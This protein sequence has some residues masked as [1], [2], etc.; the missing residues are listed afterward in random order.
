MTV[1]QDIQTRFGPGAESMI[2]P[3]VG[4][5]PIG[6]GFI[7]PAAVDRARGALVG[8]AIGEALGEPVEDRSRQWIAARFG[9]INGFV[10]PNPKTGSDTLLTLITA[11]SLLAD[12]SDHPTRFAARILGASIDTRGVSV[13]H[14]QAA[15]QAGQQWWQAALADSAGTAGAARCA[16]FGLLW[17]GDPQRA[18]YEAA[19]ST[20]VTHGHPAATAGAAAFAAAVA[21]AATGDGPLDRSWLESVADIC[22]GFNQGSVNGATVAERLRSL[23]SMLGQ[24]PESALNTIGTSPVVWQAVPAALWCAAAH[25]NPVA[26]VLAAVNAGGDTDTIAAMTGA[27]LG[28]RFGDGAWPQQLRNVDGVQAVVDVADRLAG[29]V[30]GPSPQNTATNSGDTPVHVSFLLDRSGSM[31]GLVDDVIGGFNAFVANQRT[32]TGDCAFTA[33]QFDSHNPFEIIHAAIPIV[34]VPNLDQDRY[35][36]RGTTPLLDALGNLITTT[37]RRVSSSASDEDQIIV[38]FTDGLENASSNWT[39]ST[40]FNLIEKKK[41][42]GWTFVFLGANQDAYGEGRD[43]G[44]DQRNIQTYRGDGRGTREAWGSVDRAVSDYRRASWNEKERRKTDLF[45]GV[46]E[47]EY[48]HQTR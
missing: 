12:A 10:V 47:A 44:F 31:A 48:D 27:C 18:A 7:C 26:G 41:A 4:N 42:E 40:L 16:A 35:R 14:A 13:L 38:V 2:P 5:P 23:P 3:V 33:V 36:P 15:L 29:H 28:A 34:S 43:L 1:T 24:A 46:K 6:S 37:E 39:R 11:D 17:A 8:A 25:D 9:V 30:P 22:T 32:V 19:L 20:S 21:L 45:D